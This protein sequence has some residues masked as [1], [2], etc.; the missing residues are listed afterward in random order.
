MDRTSV[1][2]LEKMIEKFDEKKDS[3][4]KFITIM[5]E[6][7][8]EINSVAR[9]DLGDNITVVIMGFDSNNDVVRTKVS[10]PNYF[11]KN[12]NIDIDDFRDFLYNPKKY[13]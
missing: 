7:N 1:E 8:F 2:Y 3:Y 12:M 11:V 10:N 4:E 9:R 13:F 6:F 5:N